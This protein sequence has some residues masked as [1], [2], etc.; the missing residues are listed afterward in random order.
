MNKKKSLRE[1]A[2]HTADSAQ[3]ADSRQ[4][5]LPRLITL[6]TMALIII[7]TAMVLILVPFGGQ[8]YRYTANTKVLLYHL[9]SD[10]TYGTNEY[11]FVREA[12]FEAQLVEIE[13]LGYKTIF[14]DEL[15]KNQGEKCVVLTFDDGY[16]DNY[17]NVLPLL[18][19]TT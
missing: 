9:V 12:D 4:F 8:T 6:C 3:A 10:E 17:T 7:V 18:E 16:V 15:H 1:S 5:A 11:L 19:N 14:A 13:K 2:V